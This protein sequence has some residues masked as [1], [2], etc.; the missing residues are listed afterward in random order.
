MAIFLV[1]EKYGLLHLLSR[2]P[3]FFMVTCETISV[4]HSSNG[5]VK[6]HRV[7][8]SV[9]MCHLNFKGHLFFGCSPPFLFCRAM[10]SL[11]CWWKR[12]PRSCGLA[13]IAFTISTRALSSLQRASPILLPGLPQIWPNSLFGIAFSRFSCVDAGSCCNIVEMKGESRGQLATRPTHVSI[14][15]SGDNQ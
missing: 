15:F 8:I 11:F 12:T 13:K 14:L 5:S 2:P 9:W 6:L 10:P 7:V 4:D 1:N 3:C